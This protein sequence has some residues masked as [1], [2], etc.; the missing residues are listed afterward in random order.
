MSIKKVEVGRPV[1][2]GPEPAPDM[3]SKIL[4]VIS[5][6]SIYLLVFLMPLFFLPQIVDSLY[7]SKQFLAAVFVLLSVIALVARVLFKGD[8]A[9]LVKTRLNFLLLLFV[10]GVALSS[11]FSGAKYLSFWGFGGSEPF[12]G[13]SVALVVLF[14]F[15]ARTLFID[16]EFL[17]KN[18]LLL[19]LSSTVLFLG[20]IA[21]AFL[22]GV[23]K[24]S[25]FINIFG[26][27]T[28][29]PFGSANALAIFAA[30]SFVF[31]VGIL[32]TKNTLGR[33]FKF[34]LALEAVSALV[35]L[36]ITGYRNAYLAVAITLFVFIGIIFAKYKNEFIKKINTPL[37]LF[38]VF[39]L[40][41][42]FS[43]SLA[44]FFIVPV[45]ISP[46]VKLSFEIG[47]KAM[48]EGAKNFILGSGPATFAYDFARYKP[49]LLNQTN[50]WNVRFTSGYAAIPTLMA[51]LG[52]LG[53]VSLGVFV[54]YHLFLL[55]KRAIN[56]RGGE[57]Y[58]F[59]GTFLA[60]L[61]LAIS[62]FIYP[63]NFVTFFYLFFFLILALVIA[64]KV[65]GETE[66][67][68]FDTL[69]H[70][71]LIGALS[72]IG[73]LIGAAFILF[74][75][76]SHFR[77]EI[78]YTEGLRKLSAGDT[79]GAI[80]SFSE[81]LKWYHDD[82]YY[83]TL[84]ITMVSDYVGKIN[85]GEIKEDG[86]AA[87]QTGFQNGIGFAK[88]ATEINPL[89][90]EN[91]FSLGAIY[92]N[93]IPFVT[94]SADAAVV[95]YS[96]VEKLEPMNPV[97]YL[98][99]GRTYL[100]YANFLKQSIKQAESQQDVDKE[101]IKKS[102]EKSDEYLNKSLEQLNL[103]IEKKA[104]LEATYLV[105]SQYYEA[106]G[107]I[108]KAIENLKKARALNP[109]NVNSL[110]DLGRLLYNNKDYDQ[111]ITAMENILKVVPEN[112]NALFILGLSYDAKGEKEKALTTFRKLK[113]IA[114]DNEDV[115]KIL[116]NL[117]KGLP[118][119]SQSGGSGEIV[120]PAE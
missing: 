67:F 60:F 85:R 21:I 76:L 102:Q 111:T 87:I 68:S 51:E 46:D 115:K 54:L 44:R 93:L 29:N 50:L 66:I 104:D 20:T 13:L 106:K 59:N 35:L 41:F 119:T 8:N 32:F 72:L 83:R 26:T 77:A 112:G 81:A 73:V 95:A 14:Y 28:W 69:A 61:V 11:V 1:P 6:W 65:R 62:L 78:N 37:L 36:L 39:L 34:L 90:R 109:Q 70:K 110:F 31:A 58:F 101:A 99:K 25:Y 118:A 116:D 114:P 86:L 52:L 105:L 15:L 27:A 24:I 17:R 80:T 47:W 74:I 56:L 71:A 57:D 120:Q 5:R 107:E 55:L 97:I 38:T 117:E 63:L 91:W 16:K 64:G 96:E 12:T 92:E 42:I 108:D 45:E 4:D 22:V 82:A 75:F 30:V 79:G 9:P 33:G 84:G 3:I 100:A 19:S 48:S 18:L 113:E 10:I 49:D 88:R 40:L 53:L 98:A 2:F 23:F 7:L 43:F 103:A 89:E 94:N